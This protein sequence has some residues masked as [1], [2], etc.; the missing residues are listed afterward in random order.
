[1]FPDVSDFVAKSIEHAQIIPGVCYLPG[2]LC[3]QTGLEIS[4]NRRAEAAKMA[5]PTRGL[6]TSP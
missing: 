6:L 3:N 1:M 4:A 2:V 5:A